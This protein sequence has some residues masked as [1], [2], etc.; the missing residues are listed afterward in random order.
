MVRD[1]AE[2]VW[3]HHERCDGKGY[4]RGLAGE[5]IPLGARM[6]SVIDAYDAMTSDRPYREKM[7]VTDAVRELR[8]CSG[9]Q[10]DPEVAGIF[11]ELVEKLYSANNHD[12]ANA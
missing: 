4:P 6:V 1:A 7:K 5:E 2:I 3:A 9:T 11:I 8:R 12:V 10:F